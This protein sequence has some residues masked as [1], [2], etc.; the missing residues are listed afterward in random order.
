M[1]TKEYDKGFNKAVSLFKDY[2]LD[3]KETRSPLICRFCDEILEFLGANNQEDA[4]A[5]DN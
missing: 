4:D 5:K 3:Q 1:R 2:I